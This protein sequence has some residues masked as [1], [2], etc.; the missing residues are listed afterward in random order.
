VVGAE[1]VFGLVRTLSYLVVPVRAGVV[2]IASACA[3]FAVIGHHGVA[4]R[5]LAGRQSGFGAYC[6][7]CATTIDSRGTAWLAFVAA[8]LTLSIA[9][10][11]R[12]A[13][14]QQRRDPWRTTVKKFTKFCA[15]A[16]PS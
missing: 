2:D 6:H 15:P 12:A 16:N 7:S 1:T 3:G 11:S 9:R 14:R 8:P 4:R 5:G 10:S 13:R